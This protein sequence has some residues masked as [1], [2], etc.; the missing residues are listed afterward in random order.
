MRFEHGGRYLLVASK[1]G[2]PRDPQWCANLRA[3]PRVTLQDGEAI[4]TYVAHEVTEE[5]R[6]VWWA[7]VVTTQPRYADYAAVAGRRIPL[8]VL[9]RS[10]RHTPG[11]A[12]THAQDTREL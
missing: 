10:D 8:F 4:H 9:E 11:A 12:V 3:Q 2:D 7:R 6:E 1:G 5:E